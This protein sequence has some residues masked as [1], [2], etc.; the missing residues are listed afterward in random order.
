[1][2]QL[3]LQFSLYIL[4]TLLV[5]SVLSF[6]LVII[7]LH[8]SKLPFTSIKLYFTYFFTALVGWFLTGIKQMTQDEGVSTI[9]VIIYIVS[10]FQLLLAIVEKTRTGKP[11]FLIIFLHSIILFYSLSLTGDLSKIVLISLYVIPVYLTITYV[12]FNYSWN[13][14]NIGNSIIGFGALLVVL[15]APLQLYYAT[16]VNDLDTAFF[17][18]SLCSSTGFLLFGIGFLASILIGILHQLT[19]IS[20]TDPLTGLLNRRGL[21]NA[22]RAILSI[23]QRHNTCI[24]AIA[25]DID[26]FK[27]INDSYGHDGGDLV[28]KIIAKIFLE[29]A[30]PSDICC[31]LGGEEFIII[32]PD[33]KI[34]AAI[35]VAERIRKYIEMLET[36]YKD[37]TINF[38]ASFGVTTACEKIILN[39]LIKCS[40][41]A[42]YK[43]KSE[44][45]NRVAV[46]EYM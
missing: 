17:L 28:L 9:V 22:F 45:R 40:D 18:L 37:K 31:R 43:A 44:G 25:V 20:L 34:D 36:K 5:V 30:R 26:F 46:S 39:H 6:L 12:S 41:D 11:L 7:N 23:A 38:T 27:K 15:T 29:N 14:K 4:F 24:S 10:S 3:S 8:L 13:N 1:M 32:L 42:L 2:A 19:L 16:I 33:T 21:N 35:E